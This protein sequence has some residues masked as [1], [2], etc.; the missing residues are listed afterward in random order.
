MNWRRLV[1]YLL[2]CACVLYIVW[3]VA[4]IVAW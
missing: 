3:A 4:G 2:I 1:G